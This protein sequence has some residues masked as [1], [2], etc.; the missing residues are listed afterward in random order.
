MAFI[1][2]SKPLCNLKSND[3]FNSISNLDSAG[4]LQ[5]TER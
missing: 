4:G 1:A 2:V 3:L 5:G